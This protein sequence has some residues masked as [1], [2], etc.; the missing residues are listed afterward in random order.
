MVLLDFEFEERRFFSLHAGV[1]AALAGIHVVYLALRLAFGLDSVFGTRRLFDLGG[2]HNVPTFVAALALL[3]CAVVAYKTA[4]TFPAKTSSRRAWALVCAIFVFL[5][6]D[7]AVQIHELSGALVRGIADL[8]SIMRW[9]WG[10]PYAALTLVVAAVLLPWWL[11]LPHRVQ[12]GLLLSGA[13]FV[14]SALGLETV[15]SVYAAQAG[16]AARAGLLYNAEVILE[17]AGEMLG[18]ALALRYLLLHLG[19]VQHGT[20]SVWTGGEAARA[21]RGDGE[22]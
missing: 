4:A 14:V 12:Q 22:R 15:A 7:E 9:V 18:V 19:E 2:E 3:A 17:E 8:S 1:I 10:I 20:V 6:F 5:A 16:D 21:G 11:Q 13:I